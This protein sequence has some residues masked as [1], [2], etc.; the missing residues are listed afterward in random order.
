MNLLGQIQGNLISATFLKLII[1]V[2]G[3]H[4]DYSPRVPKTLATPLKGIFPCI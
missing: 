2:R 1:S 4:C 3:G